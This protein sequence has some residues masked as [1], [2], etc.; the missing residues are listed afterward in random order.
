M[1]AR[2]RFLTRI[3]TRLGIGFTI[4]LALTMAIG[5]GA[6]YGVARLG[7]LS[8]ILYER[9]FAISTAL[10]EAQSQLPPLRQHLRDLE[11]ST[12]IDQAVATADQLVE[13]ENR[14]LA[15]LALIEGRLE[16][17]S[18]LATAVLAAVR[19]WQATRTAITARLNADDRATVLIW[20]R[21]DGF[22]RLRRID[23]Q[24]M[25]LTEEA[26]A[27]AE[28]VHA[29]AEA[30][31]ARISRV[32]V[33]LMFVTALV[34]LFTAVATTETVTGP[35]A[36]LR[37]AMLA[38][39]DGE[40]GI[41]VPFLKRRDEIGEMARAVKVFQEHIVERSRAEAA[42]RHNE[43]LLIQARDAAVRATEAKSKFLAAASHDLRQ[44][45]HA[46]TLFLNALGRRTASDEQQ[47]LVDCMALALRSMKSMFNA[48]LDISKIDA[49]VL[50]PHVS[51]FQISDLLTRLRNDFQGQAA[52]KGLHLRVVG[53]RSWIR[54][55]PGLLDS[56][57]RNL[58]SNA[59]K[60]TSAGKVVV[61]CRR[62][63][64]RLMVL[65]AD[66]GPGIP[67]DQLGTIFK[68]FYRLRPPGTV[69]DEGLG[70]GLAI[71]DRLAHLLGH[72][73]QVRSTPGRGSLFTVELP[74]LG[75]G[76]EPG[77]FPV[78]DDA[79]SPPL[80]SCS[81]CGRCA[82]RLPGQ[83]RAMLIE[84]DPTIVAAMS[85]EL[86]DWGWQVSAVTSG[87]GAL[88]L[89][90]VGGPSAP[91]PDLIVIDYQLGEA[92]SG[93]DLIDKLA[94]RMAVEVP[95]LVITG[96]TDSH[97]LAE[98]R[99]SGHSWLTKPIDSN[100]LRK[101]IFQ[102]LQRHGPICPRQE[103]SGDKS[104]GNTLGGNKPGDAIGCPNEVAGPGV[105]V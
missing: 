72:P 78:G 14:L 53:S 16:V 7:E 80:P 34:G 52:L 67:A 58:M 98:L 6:I 42:L 82:K 103:A 91:P 50:R 28:T 45:L 1:N 73:V 86:M 35:L 104:G 95:V 83:L 30:M 101:A 51:E 5:G 100:G 23:G 44:P 38:I 36:R 88:A 93:L 90:T 3:A 12:A 32:M 21:E 47:H 94:A 24:L 49:G 69:R 59:L 8:T 2:P 63:G 39:A 15:A 68:E 20:I 97:T 84:D 18:T 13:H 19:D 70:L 81:L 75:R 76:K 60:F 25:E 102:A 57:L 65:V 26:R 29:E 11:R 41:A 37:Q 92:D 43:S 96:S 48:L 40:H 17:G 10:L 31:R 9:P 62:R 66:S 87:D 61:G 56:I 105:S 99:D 33:V 54:S 46:L 55:D 89:A 85:H 74:Y 79:W 4:I 22:P 27:V 77:A 64:D 71:V